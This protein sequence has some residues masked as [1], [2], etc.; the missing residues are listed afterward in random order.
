[1]AVGGLWQTPRD[2]EFRLRRGV[3]KSREIN[4]ELD[5]VAPA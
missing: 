4:R 1:M 2:V 5:S 3:A